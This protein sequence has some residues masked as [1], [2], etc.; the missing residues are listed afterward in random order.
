MNDDLSNF[1]PGATTVAPM[2]APA[3]LTQARLL[4]GLTKRELA[5]RVGLS[6]AAIGQY[7]SGVVQPKQSHLPIIASTLDVPQVFFA[8]GR[9]S[10]RIDPSM[11]HFHELRST[12]VGQR[13]RATTFVELIWE[14]VHALEKRVRLPT[15]RLPGFEPGSSEPVWAD[16]TAAAKAIRLAWKLQP[17]PVPHL[18][19]KMEQ[20]GIVMTHLPFAE[21]DE[22][23]RI[24]AFSTSHTPRPVVVLTPDRNVDV[25]SHRFDAAH[26][27]AHVLLHHEYAH[28][29]VRQEREANLFAAELLAPESEIAGDLG[30]RLILGR[31]AELGRHWGVSVKFLIYRSRELGLVSEVSARRAYQKLAAAGSVIPQDSVSLHSGEQPRLLSQAY[32]LAESNNL[33]TLPLLSNELALPVSRVRTFL[34]IPE[35]KPVLR[36]V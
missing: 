32:E 3:R 21:G 30:G 18:V 16:P 7:E 22:V 28:G 2:F 17:G 20:A 27:L 36:L 24:N 25:F 19:R 23:R 12:R 5:D 14:L 10:I 13:A 11:A 4:A 35:R 34:S 6:A 15:L 1:A 31:L 33:L 26:E 29:E 9:P 8:A